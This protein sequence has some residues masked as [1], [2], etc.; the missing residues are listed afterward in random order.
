MYV[1]LLNKIT[2]NWY[3]LVSKLAER[4]QAS[5]TYN[6]KHLPQVEKNDLAHPQK[7]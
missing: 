4:A 1:K 5:W 6:R 7:H 2:L 3:I